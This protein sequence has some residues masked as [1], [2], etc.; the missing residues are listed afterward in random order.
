M[1]LQARQTFS[2]YVNGYELIE[3]AQKSHSEAEDNFTAIT[4]QYKVGLMTLTDLLE[5]QAQWHTSY[6][7]LIEAKTQY[8]INRIDY[9]RAT[10]LL[11]D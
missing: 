7:N 4:E 8:Q 1:E 10:G 3:S 5:A 9:L 11:T 6:S 2:N